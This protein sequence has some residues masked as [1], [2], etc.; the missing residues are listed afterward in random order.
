MKLPDIIFKTPAFISGKSSWTEHI[1]F[2]FLL[3]EKLKPAVFVELGSHFGDSYC[4]FCQAIQS[5][6]TATRAYAVDTFLG[7]LNAGMYSRDA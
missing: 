4:A 6:G 3:I 2:A 1:P 7:D 5:I